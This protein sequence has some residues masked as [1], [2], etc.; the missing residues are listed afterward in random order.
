MKCAPGSRQ[1][2]V[3]R[4]EG[5]EGRGGQRKDVGRAELGINDC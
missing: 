3:A 2:L 1:L 5:E 4:G